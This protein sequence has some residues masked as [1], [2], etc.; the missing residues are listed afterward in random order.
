MEESKQ[1]QHDISKKPVLKKLLKTTPT[2]QIK[3]KAAPQPAWTMSEAQPLFVSTPQKSK[4]T[5]QVRTP[6]QA[7]APPKFPISKLVNELKLVEELQTL[8]TYGDKTQAD[9][10]RDSDIVS[11]LSL[12][13]TNN[14]ALQ[15][16]ELQDLKEALNKR[17]VPPRLAPIAL[18]QDPLES[19]KTKE[20]DEMRHLE[21]IV[22]RLDKQ[23][24]SRFENLKQKYNIPPGTEDEQ[25]F[26][27]DKVYNT[28][29]DEL[30]RAA[31]GGIFSRP[32]TPSARPPSPSS[33]LSLAAAPIA[34]PVIAP[35]AGPAPARPA[36]A[37]QARPAPEP[38]VYSF[39]R[40]RQIPRKPV[41]SDWQ[42]DFYEKSGWGS[43]IHGEM[44]LLTGERRQAKRKRKLLIIPVS[45]FSA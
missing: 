25:Y 33:T 4:P 10:D 9:E 1:W 30:Q 18:P 20:I 26:A 35:I 38:Q 27:I 43:R 17:L 2:K 32:P 8:R 29:H 37:P 39:I 31:Q 24:L 11:Q 15:N 6:H 42:A 12:T 28:H 19:K 13:A 21:S 5:R 23:K 14:I 36:L 7:P 40:F 22:G 45:D 41:V 3:R 34:G 16:R 44:D